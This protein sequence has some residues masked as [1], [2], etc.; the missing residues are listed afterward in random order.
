M[1]HGALP[2]MLDVKMT[3][4]SVLNL[5]FNSEESA[6]RFVQ[7]FL[8]AFEIFS[9][10]KLHCLTNLSLHHSKYPLA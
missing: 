1:A 5:L 2:E 3:L 7:Y 4:S 6:S 8:S 9:L 10:P